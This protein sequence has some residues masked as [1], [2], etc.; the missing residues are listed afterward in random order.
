MVSKTGQNRNPIAVNIDIQ[1]DVVTFGTEKLEAML[2]GV[3][4]DFGVSAAEIN[5]AIVDSR[6]IQDVNFRFLGTD[7]NTDVISFDTSEQN[8]ERKVFDIVVN[9]EMAQLQA[10]SRNITPESELALYC[11]HG[12][13]H[14]FSFDDIAED[15]AKKMHSREDEILHRCGY[16][17]VYDSN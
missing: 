15:D 6:A 5:L 8:S 12:L 10:K 7:K 2:A 3:C 1:C 13:L 14:N 4:L 17:I 11:V 16:G 9:A